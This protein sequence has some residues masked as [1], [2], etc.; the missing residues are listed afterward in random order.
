[1][2]IETLKE[3]ERLHKKY[4]YPLWPL[5]KLIEERPAGI[6]ERAGIVG[7]RL[8]L[9]MRYNECH[10]D[11]KHEYFTLDDVSAIVENEEE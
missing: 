1:M 10:A 9:V 7:V 5:V 3:L 8:S 6:S 2:K 11:E 4:D